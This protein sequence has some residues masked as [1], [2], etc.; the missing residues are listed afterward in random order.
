[1]PRSLCN[2]LYRI[3]GVQQILHID[4]DLIGHNFLR[5]TR[6][7]G[8][9]VLLNVSC[10]SVEDYETLCW[11][12]G[13]ILLIRERNPLFLAASEDNITGHVSVIFLTLCEFLDLLIRTKKKKS[14]L[15]L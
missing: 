12:F 13:L 1:M 6:A 15:V 4:T 8:D 2:S 9:R 3:S 10:T 7:S 14:V 5:L 11:N